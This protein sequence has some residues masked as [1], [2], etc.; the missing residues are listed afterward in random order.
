MRNRGFAV[1]PVL[2]NRRFYEAD[3]T[4]EHARA[5]ASDMQIV[6]RDVRVLD[7]QRA[8]PGQIK[9]PAELL[10]KIAHPVNAINIDRVTKLDVDPSRHLTKASA[11]RR[12][13]AIV[14]HTCASSTT[15]S[16]GLVAFYCWRPAGAIPLL[17][18]TR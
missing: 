3:H 18:S 12:L 8:E 10:C 7:R 6:R 14:A 13:L 15:I 17:W 11:V 2:G 5:D 9:V 4:F 1:E 16:L